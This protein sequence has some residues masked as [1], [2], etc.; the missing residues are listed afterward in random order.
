MNLPIILPKDLTG[1]HANPV[2]VFVESYIRLTQ[3]QGY[4]A[5]TL[6]GHLYLIA[7][8]G[9]WLART[10]HDVRDIDERVVKHFLRCRFGHKLPAN[11]AR[12]VFRRLL[13][14]IRLA[15]VASA[16]KPVTPSP[17]ESLIERYRRYL[18]DELGLAPS[19]VVG[20][21]WYIRKFLVRQYGGGPVKLRRLQLKDAIRFIREVGREHHG[22]RHT[23]LLVAAL[24]SFVRF[25][26]HHGEIGR[27]FAPAIPNVPHWT[28]AGLPKYISA[29]AVQ[30]VLD[31][32]ERQTP[33]GRRNYAMLL[34]L[35]RLG[36]RGGEVLR[37][38]LEDLDWESAQI[39]IRATKGPGWTRLPLP[40]DAAKAIADYLRHDRPSCE[41]RRVFLRAHAPHRGLFANSAIQLA[42]RTG[43][44]RAGV[45]APR[46]GAH[47]FRHSLAT[48][49]LKQGSSLE[50]IGQL[51]RHRSPDTT[52]LYAKVDLN[53]LRPLALPWPGGVR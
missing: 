45:T 27:D 24:R 53:A 42:V 20:Y 32:C 1:P 39:T 26:Y 22:P 52:T 29:E 25:L 21:Q 13:G 35:A 31:Q 19:T 44:K 49:M 3:G 15:D 16:E 51:L 9:R 50:D 23:Q 18:L 8:F 6:R 5:A 4:R 46:M 38:N 2:A 7:D 36:L 48:T 33:L 30:R 14:L 28:L 47:L 17:A 40:P 12:P 11:G 41:S 10:H 43:L 34:L 37:L